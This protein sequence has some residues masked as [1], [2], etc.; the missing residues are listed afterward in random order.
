MGDIQKHSILVFALLSFFAG[1]SAGKLF[2]NDYVFFIKKQLF[3]LFPK[4]WINS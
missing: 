3:L 1:I 2:Y 4:N